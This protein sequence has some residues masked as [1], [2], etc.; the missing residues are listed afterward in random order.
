MQV[1]LRQL[2]GKF[3]DSDGKVRRVAWNMDF[4]LLDGRAIA[5]I[6][7]VPGAPIGLY[8]GVMLTERQRNAVSDAIAA[9]R[10]GQA[11]AS[12]R[13][14]I[15]VPYELLDDEDDLVIPATLEVQDDE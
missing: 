4:V 5:T 12:I 15:E 2:I 13:G 1:E 6:N 14:P 7:R 10:D 9:E 3:A 11:P 8:P